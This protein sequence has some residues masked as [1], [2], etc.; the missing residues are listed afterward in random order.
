LGTGEGQFNYPQG[1]AVDTVGNVYVADT[2]NHRIQVFSGEGIFLGQWGGLGTGEGQFNYPQGITVD[3][4]GNVYVA[5]TINNR[6]KV[7]SSEGNFLVQ[8]GDTGTGEGQFN[9][10]YD[11]AVDEVG[12][13]AYVADTLND[14]IQAFEA[15]G[16]PP[17][18]EVYNFSGF[19]RPLNSER[20]FKIGRSVPVKFKLTDANGDFVSTAQ[21]SI[22]LQQFCNDE[23]IGNLIEPTSK[24]RSNV[25]NIFRYDVSDDQ[26]IYNLNTK[27][28]SEG[29]WQI[30]VFLDDGTMKYAFMYLRK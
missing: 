22:M 8:W 29:M 23:P 1:L 10:P 27:G 9:Y 4:M 12:G 6:I 26:Y 16:E 30:I 21:A 13:V 17:V 18:N 20:T 25:G 5:D 15:Y 14:R 24:G 2:F 28:L 11:I 3:T 7:F 19:L